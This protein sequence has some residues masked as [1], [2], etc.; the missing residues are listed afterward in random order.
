MHIFHDWK[1]IAANYRLQPMFKGA[2]G[3]VTGEIVQG[4]GISKTDVLW[5]CNCGKVKSTT[6]HGKWTLEQI[7]GESK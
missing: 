1:P 4:V 7:N 2:D 6:V 5:K 3:V